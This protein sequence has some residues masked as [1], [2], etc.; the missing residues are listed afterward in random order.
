MPRLLK[1]YISLIK[2]SHT[3]STKVLKTNHNYNLYS[4]QT[5]TLYMFGRLQQYVNRCR[6]QSFTETAWEA[7]IAGALWKHRLP[8]HSA[9]RW[10]T[11]VCSCDPSVTAD[12]FNSW[13]NVGDG[14]VKLM[15]GGATHTRRSVNMQV[16]V[17][18]DT[19]VWTYGDVKKLITV[20]TFVFPLLPMSVCPHYTQ[21]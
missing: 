19:I 13:I 16:S 12:W 1:M 9:D 7:V 8:A 10:G 11:E 5:W 2:L 17:T 4:P 15:Q 21:W 18:D 20:C 6:S 14:H 3:Y